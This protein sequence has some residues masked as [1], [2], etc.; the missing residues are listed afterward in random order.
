M[1]PRIRLDTPVLAL[2]LA[3]IALALGPA[4]FFGAVVAPT[5]FRVLPTRDLAGALQSPI[6]SRLCMLAEGSFAVLFVTG[7]WL[8]RGEAKAS[9]AL[10][11]RLPVLGF[12]AALVIRKL[13]IPPIDRIREEAPGLIDSLPAGDPSKVLLDRYHR[14]STGFFS[15]ELAAALLIL[16]LTARLL[17]RRGDG[18]VPSAAR[19]PM[20]KVLDL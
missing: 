18:Q 6:L 2:H 14:L 12:F 15:L 7:W 3:A 20:P 4:I 9:R 16:L 1:R 8:T 17:S 10:L 13:L 19:P 5:V 11:T